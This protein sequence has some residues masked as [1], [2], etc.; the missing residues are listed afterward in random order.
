MNLFNASTGGLN[1]LIIMSGLISEIV[2]L[3]VLTIIWF[4]NDLVKNNKY[5]S[6]VVILTIVIILGYLIYLY[7]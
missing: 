6:E 1:V 7:V 2:M 4:W 3:A 5:D